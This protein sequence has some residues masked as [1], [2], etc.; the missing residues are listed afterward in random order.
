MSKLFS[1]SRR[2]Y[3]VLGMA[4]GTREVMSGLQECKDREGERSVSER[5]AADWQ[6]AGNLGSYLDRWQRARMPRKK[7]YPVS[8]M[9]MYSLEKI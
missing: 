9:L 4:A 6:I 2:W 3:W 7:K 8:R 5:E 1:V